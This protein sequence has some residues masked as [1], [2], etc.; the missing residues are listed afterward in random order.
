[1][2]QNPYRGPSSADHDGPSKQKKS[3]RRTIL[4]V[5]TILGIIL[6]AICL[7]LPAVRS[8][9][10]AARRNACANNMK[11]IAVA[12]Q[13][14]AEIYHVLPP[15]Y[16]TDED[17]KPLHSWRT[18]ILPYLE[19]Q[20]LY[21]S[22]DLAKPW[23]DPANAEACKT[24]VDAY[25]CPSAT[26]GENYTTYLAIVTPDSCFRPTEPRD[27]SDITDGTRNTLMLIEVDSG[28]SVPWMS[29][30]DADENVVLGIGPKSSLDHAVGVHAAFVDG[31]VRF[32]FDNM[33]ASQ[34]RALIS[35]TG[36]DNAAVENLD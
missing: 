33:A 10:P 8:A 31:S 15:A 3:R 22:I 18:L 12:L 23:N 34:R 21:K 11:Q 5:M 16:T 6:V 9:R 20:P 30:V 19:E 27:L 4:T 35:I 2:D 17:G 29:P 36:D 13:A 24:S 28:H 25:R 7:L 26:D 1:M 14:Y 32:L